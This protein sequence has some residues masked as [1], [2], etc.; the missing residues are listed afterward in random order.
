VNVSARCNNEVTLRNRKRRLYVAVAIPKSRGDFMAATGRQS[1]NCP[2]CNA[3][4]HIVKIE[5]GPET[6]DGEITC[7]ACGAPL[8]GREGRH[9]VKYF[10]LRQGGRIQ[11]WRKSSPLSRKVF[12]TGG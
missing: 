4:Y 9:V 7:R 8:P 1:F 10:M 3:L 12:K 2:N 11:R 6:R 5:P